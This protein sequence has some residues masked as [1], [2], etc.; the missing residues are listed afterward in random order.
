[1]N[2]LLRRTEEILEIAQTGTCA[3]NGAFIVVDHRGSM[4]MLDPTGWTMSAVVREFGASEVYWIERRAGE[5]KVEA[6][7]R[8]GR[9]TLTK[10][11]PGA[12]PFIASNQALT[13]YP[14]M[15]QVLPQPT[16]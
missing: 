4:R 8:A 10:P 13:V 11:T 2:P 16:C 5:L 1:M 3:D 7:S 12:R 6:W 15:L 14:K 9:C